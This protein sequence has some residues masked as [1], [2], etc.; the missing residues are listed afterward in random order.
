VTGLVAALVVGLL[1][2]AVGGVA[3]T[4]LRAPRGPDGTW[5]LALLTGMEEGVVAFDAQG[6]VLF[7]NPSAARL[8]GRREV[9]KGTP[10]AAFADVPRLRSTVVASMRGGAPTARELQVEGPPSRTVQLRVTPNERGAVAVLLDVTEV[11]RIERGWRDFAATTSHELKTPTAAILANLEALESLWDAPEPT[12]RSFV[13]AARR[14]ADRLAQLV[15]DL[16]DLVR[17]EAKGARAEEELAA[18]PV[19]PAIARAVDEVGGAARVTVDAHELAVRADEWMLARV[20]SNL[21]TNALR[22]SEGP[23][24]VSARSLAD[25]VQLAVSDRGPGIPE[26]HRER[27]FERFYRVDEGRAR[28]QG[29]T[30]LGLAIVRELT[31]AMGGRVTLEPSPV[32]ARFVVDLPSAPKPAGEG[33]TPPGV[34][35]ALE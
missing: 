15:T 5:L 14:Q 21:L 4:R 34:S 35:R 6:R 10:M 23:V 26:G 20:L 33:V 16:L 18:V 25:R 32:G 19:R 11:R 30:G 24:E 7:A 8:L 27:I 31:E 12:R 13:E 17:L 28:A 9:P 29:G 1:L 3:A 2:G 22:Y